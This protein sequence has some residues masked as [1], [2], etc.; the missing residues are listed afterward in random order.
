MQKTFS[1]I[2]AIPTNIGT[3][4]ELYIK[5]KIAK[6]GYSNVE[7]LEFELLN[8]IHIVF[9]SYKGRESGQIQPIRDRALASSL[10]QGPGLADTE[11]SQRI[12]YLPLLPSQRWDTILQCPPAYDC[13]GENRAPILAN[14]FIWISLYRYFSRRYQFLTAPV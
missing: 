11:L 13:Y 1:E 3:L 8:T 6:F 12:R 7:L 2:S 9:I 5:L 10:S 4:F 14:Y